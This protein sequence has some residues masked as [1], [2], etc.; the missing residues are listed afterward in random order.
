M[1]I[2]TKKRRT[3][4]HLGLHGRRLTKKPLKSADYLLLQNN[5]NSGQSQSG[6]LYCEVVKPNLIYCQLMK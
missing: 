6:I 2:S 3:R 1:H 5:L 4:K